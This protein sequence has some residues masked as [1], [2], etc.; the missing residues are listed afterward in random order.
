LPR[1]TMVVRIDVIT[2]AVDTSPGLACGWYWSSKLKVNDLF[3]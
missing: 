1:A 3:F 2:S